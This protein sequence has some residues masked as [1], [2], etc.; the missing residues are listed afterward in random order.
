MKKYIEIENNIV[1][2]I[3]VYPDNIQPSEA[4]EINMESEIQVG[5]DYRQYKPDG[6]SYTDQE[7]LDMLNISEIPEGQAIFF[8]EGS[9]QLADAVWGFISLDVLKSEKMTEIKNNFHDSLRN[10][11][12]QSEALGILVDCRRSDVNNDLQNV[13]GLIAYMTRTGTE[14]TNYVGREEIKSDVT[15]AMLNG[16]V[17]EMQGYALSIYQKK[18]SLEETIKNATTHQEVADVN[19]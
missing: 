4:I 9:Y 7:I 11:L 14:T 2:N 1:Q 19:W 15:V 8:H 3:H 5:D 6:S 13:E 16:L 18:W 10:G 17:A 12:F